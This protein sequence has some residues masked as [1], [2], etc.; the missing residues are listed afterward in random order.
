M[1]KANLLKS[2]M[3]IRS[4][5]QRK[6]AKVLGLS[7]KALSKKMTGKVDWKLSEVQT[8]CDVLGIDDPRFCFF[9]KGESE[10]L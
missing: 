5:T 2:V 4:M 9:V 8:I 10:M 3:A 7:E 1:F 6:L